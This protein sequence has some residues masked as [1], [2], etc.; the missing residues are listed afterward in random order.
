MPKRQALAEFDFILLGAV[1]RGYNTGYSIR[2][3]ILKTRA[4]RWSGSTGAVYPALRRLQSGGYLQV[5]T[6]Q[7]DNGRA[8]TIYHISDTGVKELH[9][10]LTAVPPEEDL[11]MLSDPLRSRTLM[12]RML[13]P[14]ERVET[15]QRW[16]E[17]NEKY[18]DYVKE[19]GRARSETEHDPYLGAA[20]SNLLELLEGRRRWLDTFACSE[21]LA[22]KPA[23]KSR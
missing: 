20:F 5:T 1:Y 2:Q 11:G 6:D 22:K 9:A 13:A 14:K 15:V 7:S 16:V 10:W 19:I 21:S 18:I 23:E 3:L 4:S 8:R 17:S 12:L